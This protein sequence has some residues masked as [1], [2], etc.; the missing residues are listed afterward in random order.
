MSAKTVDKDLQA[1]KAEADEAQLELRR[2][3]DVLNKSRKR[4]QGL[5]DAIGL[6]EDEVQYVIKEGLIHPESV[7]MFR[8]EMN[9]QRRRDGGQQGEEV[10]QTSE[11]PAA[12]RKKRMI[13]KL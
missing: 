8:R 9:E 4:Y 2:R 12:P 10:P 11:T 3:R 7:E 13:V 6:T 5:L 1:L